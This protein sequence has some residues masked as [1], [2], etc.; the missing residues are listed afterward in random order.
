MRLRISRMW[1]RDYSSVSFVPELIYSNINGKPEEMG[2]IEC[3]NFALY[4]VYCIY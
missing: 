1:G 4:L 2:I 3:G